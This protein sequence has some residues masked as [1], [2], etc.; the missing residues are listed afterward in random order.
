VLSKER[1]PVDLEISPN[2]AGTRKK[3]KKYIEVHYENLIASPKI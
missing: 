2:A 3:A 1:D